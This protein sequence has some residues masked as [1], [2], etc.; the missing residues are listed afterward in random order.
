[1]NELIF[2]CILGSIALT[3]FFRQKKT[4][5]LLLLIIKNQNQMS[6]K[7]DEVNAA[8]D[9]VNEKVDKVAADVAS[10]HTQIDGIDSPTAE[11]WQ[12]TKDKVAAI[13]TKLQA[14]DDA[15]PDAT[16]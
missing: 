6:A 8:L 7:L 5:K 10:L 1:M 12:A 11:E 2:W 15:T 16:T 4:N 3:Y 13:N 14:V 9:A